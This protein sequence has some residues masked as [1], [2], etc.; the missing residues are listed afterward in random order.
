MISGTFQVKV[1]GVENLHGV[2]PKLHSVQYVQSV[3]KIPIVYSEKVI[4]CD[5]IISKFAF[6]EHFH[7]NLGQN[8]ENMVLFVGARILIKKILECELVIFFLSL[9][10]LS[11]V[12]Y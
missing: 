9:L 4:Q 10:I 1:K 6:S 2:S 7:S 8:S 3:P 12:L 5:T 11:F